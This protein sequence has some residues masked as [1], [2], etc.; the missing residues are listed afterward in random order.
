[1]HIADLQRTLLI[2]FLQ[3]VAWLYLTRVEGRVSKTLLARNHQG[4]SIKVMVAHL[5]V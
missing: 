3:K 1:M 5:V 2:Y 4:V